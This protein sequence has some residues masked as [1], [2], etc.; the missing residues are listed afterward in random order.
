MTHKIKSSGRPETF[1]FAK[2]GCLS[3]FEPKIGITMK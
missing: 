1:N 3:L 2:D